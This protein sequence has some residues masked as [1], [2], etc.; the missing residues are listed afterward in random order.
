MEE[1]GEE[2]GKSV[3]RRSKRFSVQRRYQ[4]V[5][6]HCNVSLNSRSVGLKRNADVVKTLQMAHLL[7]EPVRQSTS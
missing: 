3:H 4:V 5:R 7:D 1:D 6:R 2:V